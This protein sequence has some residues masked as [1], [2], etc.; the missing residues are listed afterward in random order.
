MFMGFF[1][2][3]K[4]R[5]KN[6][7]RQGPRPGLW[8]TFWGK[9]PDSFFSRHPLLYDSRFRPIFQG[10]FAFFFRQ[11]FHTARQTVDNLL[12]PS[13]V[14][15]PFCTHKPWRER[16]FKYAYF[17]IA[18]IFIHSKTKPNKPHFNKFTIYSYIFGH[19]LS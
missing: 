9:L 15:S 6:S 19:L 8:I 1:F 18:L 10:L 3:K 17:Y 7:R 12:F 13:M 2:G 14:V 5:K 11:G 4:S 16:L